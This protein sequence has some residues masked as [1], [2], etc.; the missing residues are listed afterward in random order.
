MSRDAGLAGNPTVLIRARC[1]ESR[2]GNSRRVRCD[3]AKILSGRRV[4]RF[5]STPCR[6]AAR[7]MWCVEIYSGW[8]VLVLRLSH[9]EAIGRQPRAA[10]EDPPRNC[11]LPSFNS[12]QR[13]PL[14]E[15]P[16]Q[17]REHN[18]HRQGR[19]QRRRHHQMPFHDVFT[20]HHVR[21]LHSERLVLR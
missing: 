14:D 1:G 11:P 20:R 4:S 3:L 12:T 17:P 6:F 9:Q 16:L 5:R 2:L 10:H 18:R 21:H 13:K 7:P 19:A 8:S 15:I